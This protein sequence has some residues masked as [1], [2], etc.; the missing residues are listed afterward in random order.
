MIDTNKPEGGQSAQGTPRPPVTPPESKKNTWLWAV[1]G[2]VAG[3]AVLAGLLFA[4]GAFSKTDKHHS[5]DDEEDEEDDV[6]LV[7]DLDE[8]DDVHDV[9]PAKNPPKSDVDD[10]PVK[11][12]GNSS[13][14]DNLKS[15]MV[16]VQGGTFWMGGRDAEASSNDLPVHEVT[17]SSFY[18]GR[19][20]VTQ[21]EWEEVMG[22]N[23]SSFVGARLPVTNVSWNDCQEFIRRLNGITGM[24]FRLPT[25]AEWEFAARGGNAGMTNDFRYSGSNDLNRVGWNKDNS[26]DKPH[27]VG[28]KTSNELGLYDMSGNVWEWC[29]DHH[30]AYD[31]SAAV[32]PRGPSSGKYRVGRGGSC[33]FGSKFSRPSYRSRGEQTLTGFDLGFRLA[34]Y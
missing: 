7:E 9:L 4:F 20:E 14:I 24:T 19:Y 1:V 13:V 12:S 26:G 5:S 33:H 15:N 16:N 29:Q 11:S 6:E 28:M 18:I 17:V 34:R 2:L 3:L 21:Q 27:E 10:R 8:T 32:D 23:P 25:E 31:S 30:A 22:Y